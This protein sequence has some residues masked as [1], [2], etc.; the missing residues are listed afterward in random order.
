MGLGYGLFQAPHC[1]CGWIPGGT[2]GMVA[3]HTGAGMLY[4]FEGASVAYLADRLVR[5]V[6]KHAREPVVE[7]RGRMPRPTPV[8]SS[9]TAAHR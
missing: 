8:G 1:A 5:Q 7:A 4:G 9:D 2:P 6:A 3:L